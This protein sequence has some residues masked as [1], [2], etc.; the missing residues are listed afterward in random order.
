MVT[1]SARPK[2]S[3]FTGNWLQT[4]GDVPFYAL[5]RVYNPFQEVAD[6]KYAPPPMV[7]V[8]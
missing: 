5:I 8:A 6:D 7:R 2:P 1:L 3:K 4:V